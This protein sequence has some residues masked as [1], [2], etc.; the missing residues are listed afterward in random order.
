M[1]FERNFSFAFSKFAGYIYVPVQ[2]QCYPVY[3]RGPC[4]PG[5]YLIKPKNR[6]TPQCQRN[7]CVQ[8][9][10]VPFRG[11]CYELDTV[12]PCS[13]PELPNVVGVNE[14]TFEIIC[15]KDDL[16]KRAPLKVSV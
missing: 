10:F 1:V 13:F 5:Q 14:T 15:T 4:A 12:G 3:T 9:N 11:G 2:K 6:G 8:D 7:P 16:Y